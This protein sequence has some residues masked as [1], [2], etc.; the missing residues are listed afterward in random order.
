M[1]AFDDFIREINMLLFTHCFTEKI[2]FKTK[3]NNIISGEFISI[4]PKNLID[5][6][7]H[8]DETYLKQKVN[9]KNTKNNCKSTFSFKN[10]NNNANTTNIL[11][12]KIS[13][14]CLYNYK[15]IICK[16][17][18]Q[19]FIFL[20]DIKID[21]EIKCQN[22]LNDVQL[23]EYQVDE[24][25]IDKNLIVFHDD[26]TEFN[27]FKINKE[28][29]NVKTSYSESHYTTVLN[30]DYI[31]DKLKAKALKIEN[32]LLLDGNQ[33]INKHIKEERGL[34]LLNDNSQNEE[35][36]EIMYSSVLRK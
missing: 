18:F 15:K 34:L 5:F 30:Y 19:F 12:F 6:L 27:Q 13:E 25:L 29:F 14:I 28:R 24:N 35:N 36:E 33:N 21:S 8:D 2:T 3:D 31:P 7:I 11:Y 4:H 23:I 22:N 20:A 16:N 9:I 1:T 17:I 26:G 10:N 32:E